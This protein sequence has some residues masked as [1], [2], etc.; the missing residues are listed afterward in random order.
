[1][2]RLHKIIAA[3]VTAELNARLS[4]TFSTKNVVRELQKVSI[5]GR[6]ADSKPL[7]TEAKRQAAKEVV[8]PS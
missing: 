5:N 7:I 4:D 2:A 6:A 8:S 1:M 3:K